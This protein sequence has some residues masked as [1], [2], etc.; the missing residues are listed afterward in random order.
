MDESYAANASG[1]F[2]SQFSFTYLSFIP[3]LVY[4]LSQIVYPGNHYPFLLFIEG[5]FCC[6]WEILDC[7]KHFESVIWKT[8]PL[9][10]GIVVGVQQVLYSGIACILLRGRKEIFA[11]KEIIKFGY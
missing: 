7:A 4:R 6:N 11:L 8:A 2:W 5:K 9:F 10:L 3:F 1:I